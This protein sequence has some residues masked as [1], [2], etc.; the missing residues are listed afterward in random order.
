MC[1]SSILLWPQYTSPSPVTEMVMF[2]GLVWVGMLTALGTFT[3]T[4]LVMTGIVIR[5]MINMT[6]MTST[7]GVVLISDMVPCSSP[8]SELPMLIDIR[9]T[10]ATVRGQSRWQLL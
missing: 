9:T 4:F 5:K 6:N 10:P 3:A 8:D 2:S 1:M 7:S